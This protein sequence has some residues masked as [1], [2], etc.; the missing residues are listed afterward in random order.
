MVTEYY[1]HMDYDTYI[2][3]ITI[4]VY[5]HGYGRFKF[6]P[7]STFYI[8]WHDTKSVVPPRWFVPKIAQASGKS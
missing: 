1:E 3:Y 7:T 6:Q 2:T 5:T 8:P 4:Y